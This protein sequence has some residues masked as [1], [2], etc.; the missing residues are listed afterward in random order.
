MCGRMRTAMLCVS[1]VV[2]VLTAGLVVRVTCKQV[3]SQQ[4]KLQED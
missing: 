3:L 2:L 4:H 1:V